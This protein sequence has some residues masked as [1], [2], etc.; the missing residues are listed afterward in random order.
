[1]NLGLVGA[2]GAAALGPI[3][4]G[5]RSALARQGANLGVKAAAD[6][7]AVHD[8]DL[9]GFARLGV[10]LDVEHE[11]RVLEGG[12]MG[13]VGVG[14]HGNKQR[15]L[16]LL[17]LAEARL[18][19]HIVPGNVVDELQRHA[20][21]GV[22]GGD[23]AEGG[24]GVVRLGAGLD[25]HELKA[26]VDDV[27]AARVAVGCLDVDAHDQARDFLLHVGH[28]KIGRLGTGHAGDLGRVAMLQ[29]SHAAHQVV[30]R[31]LA[32]KAGRRG[33]A[34]LVGANLVTQGLVTVG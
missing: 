7:A 26:N 25:L 21:L 30:H 29:G 1:M 32:G 22:H 31:E 16:H 14:L 12:V 28:V 20:L 18:V 33:V 15:L 10:A 34:Q 27:A 3:L 6:V 13:H 8:A 11:P 17:V 9:P 5:G 19:A 2:Q 23:A 4:E 24:E